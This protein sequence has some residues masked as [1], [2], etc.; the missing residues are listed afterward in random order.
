ML[1]SELAERAAASRAISEKLQQQAR[2][3]SASN[4]VTSYTL[5]QAHA[6]TDALTSRLRD[7]R[8]ML[9]DVEDGLDRVGTGDVLKTYYIM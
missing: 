8:R 6:K 4:D 9:D 7:G 2:E 3:T 1:P 5:R